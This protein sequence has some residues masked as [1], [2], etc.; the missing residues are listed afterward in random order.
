LRVFSADGVPRDEIDLDR[1]PSGLGVGPE[2]APGKVAV[3]LASE[4]VVV[5]LAERTVVET[6]PGLHPLR[7]FWFLGGPG[8]AGT[9]T[10][11]FMDEGKVL[12]RDFATGEERVVAGPGASAGERLDLH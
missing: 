3:Q 7:G 8:S 1:V 9:T 11:F 5:D 6:L 10:R 12:Q 4:T 2:V